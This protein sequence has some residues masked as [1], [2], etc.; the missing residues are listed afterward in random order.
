M[1]E[2]SDEEKVE[3]VESKWERSSGI[4]YS[5]GKT[6]NNDNTKRNLNY[7][8]IN[9]SSDMDNNR[10]RRKMSDNE[11]AIK[12]MER[13]LERISKRG[14]EEDQER[15]RKKRNR[16]RSRNR[17]LS[18]SRN[19]GKS[20]SRSRSREQ[21]QGDRNRDKIRSRRNLNDLNNSSNL[22]EIL[23]SP[24]ISASMGPTAIKTSSNLVKQSS[25][26]SLLTPSLA[27]TVSSSSF[28][29]S[30]SLSTASLPNMHQ[31]QHQHNHREDSSRI[32]NI[33][34]T[35]KMPLKWAWKVQHKM[36]HNS[37]AGRE[38]YL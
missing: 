37:G 2:E 30:R 34:V 31:H 1:K 36:E 5:S 3:E 9:N 17:S 35:R 14:E 32:A 10:K 13:L 23:P 11:E 4:S 33:N 28:T 24:D 12:H 18:R 16:N 15:A 8:K 26:A 25:V 21:G 22:D 38:K 7:D 6:N 27:G 19:R 29:M 20:R